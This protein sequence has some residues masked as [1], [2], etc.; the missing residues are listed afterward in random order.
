MSV[1]RKNDGVIEVFYSY[2]HKDEKLRDKLETH[3][4]SLKNQGMIT[5]WHDRKIEA[6]QEWEGK[7]DEHL[8]TARVILLLVSA[9]FLASRYCYD[10]EVAWAIERHE[11]GTARV[12]P[13]I[14]KPC[15]WQGA[16]FSQLQALPKDGKPVTTW[17]NRDQAFTDI[18]LGIKAAVAHIQR[19]SLQ[20]AMRRTPLSSQSHPMRHSKRAPV[21]VA[22]TGSTRLPSHRVAQRLQDV[23]SPYL[24]SHALWYCGSVGDA[25]ETAAGFLLAEH[26]QVIVVGY[27]A[28]DLS[29][30][31]RILLETYQAP[32]V[33]AQQEELPSMADAP[34]KRDILF[35]TK[36]DLVIL[37]WDGQSEG[38]QDLLQWLRQQHKD[39]LVVFV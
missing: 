31:M 7:I 8:E 39:H 35:Y 11:A 13:I 4:A 36:A 2:S 5:G 28:Y 18:A 10:V 14:L 30:E 27:S 33:D 15:D 9:D 17:T 37:I 22:I 16:P 20:E 34:S 38:T 1:T 26:Q 19:A 21:T 29:D 6:G 32:F 24:D 3:L 23:V 12:I 25:D